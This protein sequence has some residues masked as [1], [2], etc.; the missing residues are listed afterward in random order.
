MIVAKRV[1]LAAGAAAVELVSA[2]D[3]GHPGR[4]VTIRNTDATNVAQLGGPGFAAGSGYELPTG[5]VVQL[6]LQRGD[7]VHA[8]S[9]LGATLHVLVAGA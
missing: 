3:S 7:A 6:Q 9:A 2:D 1:A 5:G 4:H 8:L